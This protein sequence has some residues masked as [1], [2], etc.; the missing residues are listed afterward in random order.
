VVALHSIRQSLQLNEQEAAAR[1]ELQL[2][3]FFGLNFS[4]SNSL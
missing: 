4:N 3:G 1:E 2:V